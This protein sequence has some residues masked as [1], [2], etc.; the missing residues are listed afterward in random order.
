M[1]IQWVVEYLTIMSKLLPSVAVFRENQ[2]RNS[3]KPAQHEDAK[4]QELAVRDVTPYQV[5][6][7][8]ID[9]SRCRFW[10]FR[11]GCGDAV[12]LIPGSQETADGYCTAAPR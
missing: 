4:L 1:A 2:N 7:K 11:S 5:I 8:K 10:R 9:V 6:L 3:T 12:R